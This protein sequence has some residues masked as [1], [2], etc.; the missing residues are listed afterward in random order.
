[1][2]TDARTNP[3]SNAGQAIERLLLH[4]IVLLMTLAASLA[5]VLS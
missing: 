1:M 3:E 2:V 5:A 4:G